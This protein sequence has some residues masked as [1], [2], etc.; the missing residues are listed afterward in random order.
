MQQNFLGL[1][2]KKGERCRERGRKRGGERE[3]EGGRGRE[4][5]TNRRKERG[6]ERRSEQSGVICC[7]ISPASEGPGVP[8]C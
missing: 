3:L 7:V 6:R 2:I 1:E 8:N 5:E 4:R